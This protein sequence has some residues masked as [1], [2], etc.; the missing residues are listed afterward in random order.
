MTKK[1]KNKVKKLLK[2]GLK[3]FVIITSLCILLILIIKI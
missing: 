1:E 3:S 2:T